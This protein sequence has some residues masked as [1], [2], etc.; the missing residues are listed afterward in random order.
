MIGRSKGRGSRSLARRN[1]PGGAGRW[2]GSRR[3]R[4]QP[5][6]VDLPL[7]APAHRVSTD[8]LPGE[9]VPTTATALR[10]Y[11]AGGPSVSL[12]AWPRTVGSPEKS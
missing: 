4:Q 10:S 7:L 9:F 12:D 11:L 6:R 2:S 8:A 5:H 3:G 1:E